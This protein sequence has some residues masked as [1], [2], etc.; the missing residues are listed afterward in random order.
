MHDGQQIRLGTLNGGGQPAA[1]L[2]LTGNFLKSCQA[3]FAVSADRRFQGRCVKDRLEF[4]NAVGQ[5]EGSHPCLADIRVIRIQL[6][7]SINQ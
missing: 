7:R 5:A 6:V 3:L 2:G 4:F 1:S